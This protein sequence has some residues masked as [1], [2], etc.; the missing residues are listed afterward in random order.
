M[1]EFK[2]PPLEVY[3]FGS[4]ILRETMPQVT[5][6]SDEIRELIPRMY[7]TMYE[8]DGIGLSAN[9]VGAPY[10]LAVIGASLLEEENLDDFV[11]INGRVL[12]SEGLEIMEEGCLSFPGI[13]VEI[14]RA[15]RI[16][17]SYQD[18]NLQQH[19]EEFHDF[20]ARVI[21]HELDHLNGVYFIDR[22][23]PIKRKLL[24]KQLKAISDTQT[25]HR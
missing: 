10:H 5:E 8:E 14:E 4:S 17:L 2:I 13:R 16:V 21:Q 20:L 9:Q 7:A 12:E 23:A 22:I 24:K 6:I 18:E 19:T 1:T 25:H 3:K 11:I 15:T